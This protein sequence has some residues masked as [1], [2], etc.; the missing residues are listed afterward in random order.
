ML[1]KIGQVTK[2]SGNNSVIIK[3]FR[4]GLQFIETRSAYNNGK[5]YFKSWRI[6]DYKHSR[7]IGMVYDENGPIKNSKYDLDYYA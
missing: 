1:N 2:N 3:T 4:R 7:K 6:D 5:L